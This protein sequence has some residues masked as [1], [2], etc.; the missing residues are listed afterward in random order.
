MFPPNEPKATSWRRNILIFLFLFFLVLL[1]IQAIFQNLG[2]WLIVEDPLEKAA[3]IVILGGQPPYRAMEGASLYKGGWAPEIWV[4]SPVIPEETEVLAE[5]GIEWMKEERLNRMILG[6]LGVPSSAIRVLPERVKNTVEEV[7]LVSS[8][9]REKRA[10]R[11]ILVTSKVHTR[12]TRATW[13]ALVGKSPRAIVRFA[14]RD[15]FSPASWWRYTDDALA[16]V[17]EIFGLLN[18]WAGFPIQPEVRSADKEDR[19]R[20]G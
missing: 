4:L 15:P 17:R 2:K 20:N 1:F 10:Q 13:R 18:V 7:R 12:R 14:K 6:R 3:A 8:L 16:V 9:L 19:D 5:M 11:V